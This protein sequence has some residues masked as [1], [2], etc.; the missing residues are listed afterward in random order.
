MKKALSMLVALAMVLTL[1]VAV[2]PV[3]NAAATTLAEVTET[4]TADKP[5]VWEWEATAD[6]TLHIDASPEYSGSSANAAY[7][8]NIYADKA[9][10]DANEQPSILKTGSYHTPG[11]TWFPAVT[12]YK[13]GKGNYVVVT[14][15]AQKGYADADGTVSMTVTFTEGGAVEKTESVIA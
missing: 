12:D 1:V 8:V 6:G 9:Q 3:T 2:A 7:K 15:A 4:V 10:F 13:V 11:D 5:Y 14:L